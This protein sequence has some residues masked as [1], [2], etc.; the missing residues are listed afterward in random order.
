MRVVTNLYTSKRSI[1]KSPKVK[2]NWGRTE[3][4][5]LNESGEVV[6]NDVQKFEEDNVGHFKAIAFLKEQISWGLMDK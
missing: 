5:M 1:L 2:V 3:C 6:Y 4:L